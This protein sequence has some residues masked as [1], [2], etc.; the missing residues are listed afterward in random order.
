MR[1]RYTN[2][3]DKTIDKDRQRRN[4]DKCKRQASQKDRQMRKMGK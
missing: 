1:E 3:K 4:I 2:E